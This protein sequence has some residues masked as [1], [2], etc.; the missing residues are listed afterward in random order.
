ME[1]GSRVPEAKPLCGKVGMTRQEQ[2][3]SMACG[4][5]SIRGE[6]RP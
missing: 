3:A 4:I 6:N 2:S 5:P 1:S